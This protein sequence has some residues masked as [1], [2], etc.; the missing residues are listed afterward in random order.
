MY[1]PPTKLLDVWCM[2]ILSKY[3]ENLIIHNKQTSFWLLAGPPFEMKSWE[4]HRSRC[5]FLAR[6]LYVFI[7]LIA[8]GWQQPRF[9]FSLPVFQRRAATIWEGEMKGA[10]LDELRGIFHRFWVV[11]DC[12]ANVLQR[13]FEIP[14]RSWGNLRLVNLQN[15][16]IANNFKSNSN[17]VQ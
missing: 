10:P 8:L 2:T 17:I 1:C 4:C 3:F 15:I 7:D 12:K 11:G 9:C 13:V 16:Q 5:C 14:C 6:I